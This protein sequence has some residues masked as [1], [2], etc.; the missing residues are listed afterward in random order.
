MW[1]STTI[2]MIC[3]GA[4]SRVQ[5]RV[6]MSKGNR[7]SLDMGGGEFSPWGESFHCY[8]NIRSSRSLTLSHP[9]HSFS[10]SS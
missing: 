10:K 9:G 5:P 4:G 2:L 3:F 1:F 7:L 8:P 6:I